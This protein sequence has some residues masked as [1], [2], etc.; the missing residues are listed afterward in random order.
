M[1]KQKETQLSSEEQQL[2]ANTR[3]RKERQKKVEEAIINILQEN[4]ATLGIDPNS[5]F[6]NPMIVVHL[7]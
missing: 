2:I 5:P 1:S 6:G 3:A 4:D 7:K